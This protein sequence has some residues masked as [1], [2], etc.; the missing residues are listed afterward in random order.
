MYAQYVQESR[1]SCHSSILP[2]TLEQGKFP[3]M[4]STDEILDVVKNR[5]SFRLFNE[6]NRELSIE[7]LNMIVAHLQQCIDFFR[8]TNQVSICFVDHAN[9]FDESVN[10]HK[11]DGEQWIKIRDQIGNENKEYL[12]LQKEMHYASGVIY[13]E[14]DVKSLSQRENL[15]DYKYMLAIS[16]LLGHQVSLVVSKMALKGTVFAGI[17]LVEFFEEIA[18][19]REMNSLPIFAFAVQ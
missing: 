19:E 2:K 15:A 17:T 13:F 14:W 4:F 16:G 1:N 3:I 18:K 11:Y 5:E 7:Q 8:L 12:Y 10:V 9:I 6:N